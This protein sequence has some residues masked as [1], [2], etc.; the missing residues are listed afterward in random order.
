MEDDKKA[1]KEEPKVNVHKDYQSNIDDHTDS[2]MGWYVAII[3]AAVIIFLLGMLVDHTVSY[4]HNNRLMVS[5]SVMTE[6]VGF[7]RSGFFGGSSISSNQVQISGVV[8]AVNSSSFTIAGNGSNN[9]VQTNSSTQYFNA[10]KVS[11]NDSVV[12]VGT[13]NNSKFTASRVIVS[14]Q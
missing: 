6:R 14:N 3:V 13:T 9:T 10:S 5:N 2:K 7:G 8:T 4:R 1:V 11:V 12:V